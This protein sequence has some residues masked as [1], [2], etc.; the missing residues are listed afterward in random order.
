MS[1]PTAVLLA[2]AAANP[3]A[4]GA[5]ATPEAEQPGRV[6]IQLPENCQIVSL[7]SELTGRSAPVN[8]CQPADPDGP[9]PIYGNNIF[10]PNANAIA[11]LNEH[12]S[13]PYIEALIQQGALA[14]PSDGQLRPDAPLTH[15]E[16]TEWLD[17][18][19]T[20]ASKAEMLE[21]P[22]AAKASESGADAQSASDDK[23]AAKVDADG[24]AIAAASASEP[25]A[26]T[27]ARKGAAEDG[28]S[29]SQS[30]SQSTKPLSQAIAKVLATLDRTGHNATAPVVAGLRPMVSLLSAPTGEVDGVIATHLDPKANNPELQRLARKTFE[31]KKTAEGSI[32]VA[33]FS[34]EIGRASCRERV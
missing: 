20:V 7:P 5:N 2:L 22:E 30:T 25:G 11:D 29:T 18:A 26:E 1:F 6:A 15:A 34:K 3:L 4:P 23:A 21:I 27:D 10:V 33:R 19:L 32:E 28:Q 16:L 14:A 9:A 8:V 17:R 12:W 31:V 24:A 13:Q